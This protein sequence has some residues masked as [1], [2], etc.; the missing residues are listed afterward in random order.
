MSRTP[1]HPPAAITGLPAKAVPAEPNTLLHV[2]PVRP[3]VQD[4]L[5]REDEFNPLVAAGSLPELSDSVMEKFAAVK[6]AVAERMGRDSPAIAPGDDVVITPLGTGSAVPTK[7][8]NG[9]LGA[10][11]VYPPP[12]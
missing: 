3:P 5:A 6:A 9:E 7:M 4:E 1:A 12:R 11:Q 10:V 2:R 8:R